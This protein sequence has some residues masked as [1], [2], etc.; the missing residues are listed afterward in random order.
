MCFYPNYTELLW[1]YGQVIKSNCKA[2]KGQEIEQ[3]DIQIASVI[4]EHL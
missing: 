1:I 3:K 4:W 2:G